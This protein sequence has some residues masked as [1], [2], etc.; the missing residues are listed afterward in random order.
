MEIT[1]EKI[2][3]FIE[4]ETRRIKFREKYS[5]YIK[6]KTKIL[7]DK[8]NPY[9]AYRILQPEESILNIKEYPSAVFTLTTG[10]DAEEIYDD[11][12]KGLIDDIITSTLTYY[13]LYSL[14]KSL[15]SMN[16]RTGTL[17]TPGNMIPIEKSAEIFEIIKPDPKKISLNSKMIMS[18]RYSLNGIYLDDGKSN[19]ECALCK[20]ERCLYKNITTRMDL[21]IK[22]AGDYP[23]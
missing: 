13:V 1:A 11:Y 10:F 17:V 5:S 23:A 22:N 20:S 19:T 14:K 15:L 21:F 9:Y 8:C 18:P 16:F 7:F 4:A 2:L 6:D 12:N 3:P